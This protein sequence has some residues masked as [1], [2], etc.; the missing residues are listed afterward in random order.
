MSLTKNKSQCKAVEV[1]VDSNEKN[2]EDF[3]LDFA[4]EFGLRTMH[5]RKVTLDDL[6]PTEC[7]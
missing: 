3:C 7:D 6:M 2:S 1:T 4:Q 5:T